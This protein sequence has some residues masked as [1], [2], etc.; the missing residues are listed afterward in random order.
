MN[1]TSL[2]E[3]GSS[4]LLPDR[5]ILSVS[6]N[7]C[8]EST[9]SITSGI[10]HLFQSDPEC[11]RDVAM[12]LSDQ[13]FQQRPATPLQLSHLCTVLDRINTLFE[14]NWCSR[15]VNGHCWS[16]SDHD[17]TTALDAVRASVYTIN[18]TDTESEA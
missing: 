7:Q 13:E 18:A 10:N 1:E 8:I 9:R 2:P 6:L 11:G 15:L 16:R 4:E 3:Y 17:Q 14:R 5:R 12:Q